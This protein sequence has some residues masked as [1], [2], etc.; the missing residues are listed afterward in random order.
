ALLIM[1]VY[2]YTAFIISVLVHPSALTRAPTTPEHVETL[3]SDVPFS[4]MDHLTNQ[5]ESREKEEINHLTSLG[6]V[7][8]LREPIHGKHS[9][10]SHLFAFRGIPYAKPPIGHLRWTEPM[11][12]T[13]WENGRLDA[14]T[15]GEFCPQ[16]DYSSARVLGQENCLFLNVFTP[17]LPGNSGLDSKL[18]VFVF[19][20]GGGYLRGSSSAHGPHKLLTKD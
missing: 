15:F 3:P 5:A 9:G 20:H 1:R 6:T 8:G 2:I 4:M 18:P 19:L 7:T 13:S 11:P 12:V 10:N 14:R 16:Y 17:K